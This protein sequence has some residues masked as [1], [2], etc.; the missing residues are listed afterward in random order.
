MRHASSQRDVS[1]YQFSLQHS[2][3]VTSQA[4]VTYPFKGPL[5]R[6][7]ALTDSSQTHLSRLSTRL[8]RPQ[9]KPSFRQTF[10]AVG[11][12]TA[13]RKG[14]KTAS[15]QTGPNHW[16]RVV[17]SYVALQEQPQTHKS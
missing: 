5:S 1:V 17:R 14:L 15:S 3:C 11:L 10:T 6:V 9:T 12:S 2:G 13:D 7:V 8:S 4:S 16:D